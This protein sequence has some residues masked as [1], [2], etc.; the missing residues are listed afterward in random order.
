MDLRCFK[1]ENK[2]ILDFVGVADANIEMLFLKAGCFGNHIGRQLT[3][4][5]V[6]NMGA[7]K[8]DVN[9]QNPKAVGFYE[10]MGFVKT[11]RSALDG[12]GNPFP[13]I[14]MRLTSKGNT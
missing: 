10:R 5:A 4:Y 11:G 1:S 7:L 8:V 12:Q 14:H 9:E 3:E 6:E 13:L 2:E